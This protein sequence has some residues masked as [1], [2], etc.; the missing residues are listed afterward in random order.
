MN[1]KQRVF[2]I[3]GVISVIIYIATVVEGKPY[4]TS[5]AFWLLHD[6]DGFYFKHTLKLAPFLF[7]LVLIIGVFYLII[8]LLR[9]KEERIPQKSNDEYS[10][11]DFIE[12][13]KE[14]EKLKERETITEEEFK[15]AKK[16]ILEGK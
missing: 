2:L 15:Q 14:L 12:S 5:N 8:W 13:L 6:C 1:K 4:Y 11:R 16:K 10:Q 7:V 3:I 9:T